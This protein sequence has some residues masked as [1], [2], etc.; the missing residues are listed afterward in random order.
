MKTP[1]HII[2]TVSSVVIIGVSGL[3]YYLNTKDSGDILGWMNSNW[4]YRRSV[5]VTNPSTT[6][7]NEHVLVT[8]NTQELISAGK[9][10]NNCADI[11]FVDEDGSTSIK[12]WIEGGCNTQATQVWVEVPSVPSG[13]K[14]TYMYYGNS[15]AT[16]GEESWS[17]KFLV[18]KDTSCDT[19]WSTESGIGG[20]F[21]QRFPLGSSSYGSTGGSASHDHG[22]YNRTTS[23]VSTG[24]NTNTNAGNSIAGAHSHTVNT[25]TGSTNILPPYIDMVVCSNTKIYT[26]QNMIV[27]NTPT[28]PSGFTRFSNLDNKFPRGNSSYGGTGGATSHT[29]SIASATTSQPSAS[30]TCG[31]SSTA[32]ASSIHTHTFAATTSGSGTNLPIYKTTIFSKYTDTSGDIPVPSETVVMSN[33]LPPLGWDAYTQLDNYFP[34]GSSSSGTTGGTA[35]HY[36]SLPAQTS[37]AISNSV[38]CSTSTPRT[39]LPRAHTHTITAMNTDTVSNNPPYISTLF[40]KKKTSLSTNVSSTEEMSNLNPNQPSS[41]Q[42]EEAINPTKITNQTPS[43]TAIFSD[44]DTDD[45]GN[46]YQIEVNS[47]S[48]FT[49]DVLWDSTKTVFGSPVANNTRSSSIQ[50]NGTTLAWGNTYYWRIKFWDNNDGESTWSTTAQ[51]SMNNPPDQPSDLLVNGKVGHVKTLSDPYF[52]STYTDTDEDF[53]RYFKIQV[54]TNSSFSGTMLWD[55]G[56]VELEDYIESGSSSPNIIYDGDTLSEKTTYYWRMKYWDEN[57]IEGAWS[58]TKTF[59]LNTRPNA[60]SSLR[61]NNQ[62]NPTSLQTP[63]IKF[64]ALYTDDEDDPAT[65]YRIQVN[66]SPL[67]IG[68]M[69]WDSGEVELEEPLSSGEDLEVEYAGI[70]LSNTQDTYYWKVAFSDEGDVLGTWSE[71]GSFVDS[72]PVFSI[73][74]IKGSGIK[75]D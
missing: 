9:L 36:H 42:T 28:I 52:S 2:A 6:K 71:A 65:H 3:I 38:N 62:Q 49:G 20:D 34:Y 44:N 43:F 31:A 17:G 58:T 32:T 74:G 19:G 5:T 57:D 33:T 11:R 12:Y 15:S 24:S 22:T 54:N 59:F 64:K 35:T 7:T 29:H 8:V 30:R 39:S 18:F 10:Q 16:N 60:P 61:T 4:L 48:S 25:V 56:K 66:S 63:R 1:Y 23:T 50:Y 72:F 67:F 70:A 69:L 73:S 55:S 26:K 13:E 75:I 27:I 53:G 68:T 46:Y 21:Y 41:L 14:T 51:F 37:G 47:N 45:T 40:V